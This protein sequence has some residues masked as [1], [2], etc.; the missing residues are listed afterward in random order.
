MQKDAIKYDFNKLRRILAI[1]VVLWFLIISFNYLPDN[2]FAFR[3][4][5]QG[6]R[7]GG[8]NSV[9]MHED[10]ETC[11]EYAYSNEILQFYE[12][13]TVLYVS[14]CSDGDI[15][16]D[17][18]DIKQWFNRN[19]NAEI[20]R[21]NYFVIEDH[22]WFTTTVYYKNTGEF[23]TID[24]SG[25]FSENKLILNSYSHYNDHEDKNKEYIRMN[26]EQ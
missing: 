14:T 5:P 24:L 12:D 15:I 19:T 13:G 10:F 3:P 17:W 21:G 26:V 23:V 4:T 20:S 9:Y 25:I 16:N 8:V 1:L 22:I 2:E 18:A 6:G 11:G 7:S